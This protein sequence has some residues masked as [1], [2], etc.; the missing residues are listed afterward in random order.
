M[1]SSTSD[2]GDDSEP[3]VTLG[4]A[5]GYA[6]SSAGR[7]AMLQDGSH[8]SVLQQLNG[9]TLAQA[10]QEV[11]YLGLLQ[12]KQDMLQALHLAA[13]YQCPAAATGVYYNPS[14]VRGDTK[15]QL[16]LVS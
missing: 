11:N 10:Q 13:R 12:C 4:A 14:R 3:L 7:R 8:N 15:V 16:G 9:L 2:A 6:A 5:G 1:A